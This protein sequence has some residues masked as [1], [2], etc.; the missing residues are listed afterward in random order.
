MIPKKIC[1]ERIL[2]NRIK[3]VSSLH[4]DKSQI[5][6][7][8]IENRS[9]QNKT[10]YENRQS[11]KRDRKHTDDRQYYQYVSVR[12]PTIRLIS[13]ILFRYEPGKIMSLRIDTLSQIISA[14]GVTSNGTYIVYENKPFDSC[15]PIKFCT[16]FCCCAMNFRS[17]QMSRIIYS[18]VNSLLLKLVQKSN[19]SNN[20]ASEVEKTP[21]DVIENEDNIKE[22]GVE[23][24]ISTVST[25]TSIV[26]KK[27]SEQDKKD[28]NTNTK[29]RKYTDDD[30]FSVKK[31]KWNLEADK[32]TAILW[33]NKADGL[34]IVTREHPGNILYALLP[35][36]HSSRPFV[37][38]CPCLE[39]LLEVYVHLKTQNNTIALR[40][41]ETFSRKQQVRSNSTHP[42]ITTSGGGGY[43]LMGIVVDSEPTDPVSE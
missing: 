10:F 37:V 11:R 20:K 21:S 27:E 3:N 4:D 34:I 26:P 18:N 31:A 38:F 12:W 5:I 13:E 41:T 43:L 40:L 33:P 19:E 2:P 25:E 28:D 30:E 23:E 16:T 8:V 1:K 22:S 36:V 14:A 15:T 35:Y 17:E 24:K 29:K 42:D 7:E 6:S 32:A 9:Q 39:P